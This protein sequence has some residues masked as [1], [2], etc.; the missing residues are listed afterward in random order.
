MVSTKCM[1]DS[2]INNVSA[3][4]ARDENVLSSLKIPF[5]PTV[6][7][8]AQSVPR[9]LDASSPESI[10]SELQEAVKLAEAKK[11]ERMAAEETVSTLGEQISEMGRKLEAAP[12]NEKAAIKAQIDGLKAQVQ[13]ASSRVKR[14]A[15]ESWESQR[16]VSAQSTSLINGRTTYDELMNTV[17]SSSVRDGKAAIDEALAKSDALKDV[18]RN[19]SR[20][21]AEAIASQISEAVGSDRTYAQKIM[22]YHYQGAAQR[23]DPETLSKM[24]KTDQ[25]LIK[26]AK[27]NQLNPDD[28]QQVTRVLDSTSAYRGVSIGADLGRVKVE[29]VLN[30]E[31]ADKSA[32]LRKLLQDSDVKTALNDETFAEETFARVYDI[33]SDIAMQ[34]QKAVQDNIISDI[35]KSADYAKL[36]SKDRTFLDTLYTKRTYSIEDIETLGRIRDNLGLGAFNRMIRGTVV[37]AGGLIKKAA[38]SPFSTLGKVLKT[39]FKAWVIANGLMFVYFAA[40]EGA[41]TI[42]QMTGWNTPLD[43]YMEFMDA[44]GIPAMARIGEILGPLD[45]IMDNVPFA[46][47]LFP[48][49]AG[50]KWYN[51]QAV[52]AIMKDKLQKGVNGGLWVADTGCTFGPGC[53]GHIRPESERP[54][55]WAANPGTIAFLDGDLVRRI[56]DIQPDGTVGPNNLIAQGL[57]ITDPQQA[58]Q[59]GTGHLIAA[60]NMGAKDTLTKEFSGLYDTLVKGG[61][62]AEMAERAYADAL[63][64]S[65]TGTALGGIVIDPTA[66]YLTTAGTTVLGSTITDPATVVGMV[67]A[68]GSVTPMAGGAGLGATL[69]GLTDLQQATLAV[70]PTK[71][72]ALAKYAE[73]GGSAPTS[74]RQ[75][76]QSIFVK[77]DGSLDLAKLQSVYPDMTMAEIDSLFPDE[78]INKFVKADLQSVASDPKAVADKLNQ[79]KASG[80]INDSARIEQFLSP[81][82]AAVFNARQND[83]SQFKLTAVGDKATWI[84]DTGYP[85]TAELIKASKLLN[86][87]TGQYDIDQKRTE[88]DGSE[89]TIDTG[90]YAEWV[91]NG[92]T[93]LAAFLADPNNW[94][95]TWKGS[96]SSSSKSSSKSS[97]GSS[98]KSYGSSSYSKSTGQTGFYID[99]G[100]INAEVWENSENIGTTDVVITVEAGVHTVTVKKTGYKSYTVPIQVYSG[101]IARKS[102]TLYEDTSTQT[103]AQKYISAIGGENALNADHIVYA[104]AVLKNNTALAAIA[105]SNA[106]PTISGSWSFTVTDVKSLITTYEG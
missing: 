3:S 90:K 80:L 92:G 93:D 50:F 103:Q 34:Y 48:S 12:K 53:Y 79:Y 61:A 65:G 23:I 10:A 46:S 51:E 47:L 55:Y 54:A 28:Y 94:V 9:I 59:V 7:D 6:E 70:A 39:G 96:G 26:K 29:S 97:G 74:D 106:V 58:I 81:A 82:D 45:W 66:T 16:A 88:A 77:P 57:G 52:P 37:G 42:I 31:I 102:V 76:W 75:A 99:A 49:A 14:L 21:E 60:G 64:A 67:N 27:L 91:N 15:Q 19:T 18:L 24:T 2:L 69:T 95:Q 1:A 56:Y 72:D 4:I 11:A 32:E 35:K 44:E 87:A 20:E 36:S 104:Y 71:A 68:D 33:N 40:E 73:Y 105:K 30:S 83:P 13:G 5:T 62:T 17:R 86:P 101:S 25:E 63:A 89:Y 84:D 38:S 85:H 98:K 41:Q 78:A 100:G 8:A 22:N 43:Q